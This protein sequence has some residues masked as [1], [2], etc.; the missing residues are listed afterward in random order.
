MG[1]ILYAPGASLAT[2]IDNAEPLNH[3]LDAKRL[4]RYIRTVAEPYDSNTHEMCMFPAYCVPLSSSKLGYLVVFVTDAGKLDW[5]LCVPGDSDYFTCDIYEKADLEIQPWSKEDFLTACQA[6]SSDS[7]FLS[8]ASKA[9]SFSNQFGILKGGCLPP[10]KGMDIQAFNDTVESLDLLAI[11]ETTL[12]MQ[13]PYLVDN[14]RNFIT[15]LGVDLGTA[16]I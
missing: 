12:K 14:I 10:A 1:K 7:R 13:L 9:T 5:R 11:Y 8:M 6:A 4:L 15:D 16:H 2:L 3:S